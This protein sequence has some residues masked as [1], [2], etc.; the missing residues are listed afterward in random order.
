MLRLR[1]F[2][3][4]MG[5]MALTIYA[6]VVGRAILLPLVVAIVVWY[7]INVLANSFHRSIFIPLPRIL[8]LPA[9]VVV[10]L[11]LS[12]MLA[13]MIGGNLAAIAETFPKY[14]A[15]LDKLV[16]DWA[17]ELG[18]GET[19]TLSELVGTLDVESIAKATAAAIAQ[20]TSSAA[21]VMVY[22]IFLLL[23]QGGFD[24]KLSALFT[25]SRR[26]AEV[27]Q[28]LTKVAE[29]MQTYLRIKVL[30]ALVVTAYGWVVLELVG[31]DFAAFWAALFFLF[32][33]I[34]TIGAPISLV[35]PALFALMQFEA[36]TPFLV[37]VLGIGLVQVGVSNFVE[38]AMMGRSLNLSPFV[39]IL[40]LVVFGTL[41]GLVGMV[42][43]V[44]ILV[45]LMILLAHFERTRGLA[46]LLSANG[47]IAG[48]KIL[49]KAEAK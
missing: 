38:P 4:V 45:S 30:L 3:L 31:V 49:G 25:S 48:P 32:Y 46:V 9:A 11:A 10:F 15:R 18:L 40:A 29:D 39:I 36:I 12:W 28:I 24:R 42:L 43:C 37:V 44:P 21:L 5:V 33:F 19:R 1:N 22:V 26:E 35:G 47:E 27:R 8:C 14:Q 20:L 13:D 6:M 34:P 17:A 7:L 16:G 41:W 2:A 23:E